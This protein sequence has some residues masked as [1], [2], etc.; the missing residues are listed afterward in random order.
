MT[1]TA[2]P[3]DDR[4]TAAHELGHAFA[5]RAIGLTPERLVVHRIMGGGW[6]STQEDR[7]LADQLW[8]YAVGVA[9]GRAAEE[10]YRADA[11]LAG[12]WSWGT[13]GDEQIFANLFV[14]RDDQDYLTS[15]TWSQAVMEA[16]SLLTGEWEEL[17]PLI[18]PLAYTGTLKGLPV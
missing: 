11:G 4:C 2:A 7:V 3:V 5:F 1:E 17:A 6:C 8:G 10:I 18:Q 15:G 16:H 9:A 13:S 14:P 12:P